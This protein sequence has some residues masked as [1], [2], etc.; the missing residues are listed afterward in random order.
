MIEK[1]CISID[2]ID[3]SEKI[4][5]NLIDNEEKIDVSITDYND[6]EIRN[7]IN[8]ITEE[9]EN[10]VDKE[11]NKGLSTNDYTTAE[12]NKLANLEN[13]DDTEV[14]NLINTK[15][16]KGDYALK[17]EIPTKTS[18]LI[19]DSDFV[20][21]S[22]YVH[23]DNNYTTNEKTKLASLNNY[24]DTEIKEDITDLET[25]KAD[26]TEIPDVSNFITNTVDNLVNYYKKSE[27]YTQAEVNSLISTLSGLKLEVVQ[28]LPTEDISTS[29][30]YL[31]PKTTAETGDVYDEYIYVSNNWEHIGSTTADLTGYVKNT[32]YA[33]AQKGGVVKTGF[34]FNVFNSGV[35]YCSELTYESYNTQGNNT[36]IGKATLENVITGKNLYSKP[37]DGIPKTDL[38]SSVQTSLGKADTA[39]QSSDLADYVTNTDY[40]NSATGGVIKVSSTTGTGMSGAG[41]LYASN[42]SY[43]AYNSASD[44]YFIGKGTLENV[45]EGKGIATKSDIPKYYIGTSATGASTRLK[46]VE[47]EGF[48][49]EEGATISVTFTNAQTYNGAPQLNVNDT[50]AIVVQSRAGVNGVRYMWSAGEIIDFTYD[51]TYWVCHGRGFATTSYY[52]LTKLST[53][54]GSDTQSYAL[55]PRSL[56]Y[57]ANYSIAPYYSSSATYEV[58][59]KVRYTYYLYECN[60]AIETAEAWNAEH[61]TQIATVQE[62]IDKIEEGKKYSTSEKV[63]GTWI[64]N[65][66]LYQKTIVLENTTISSSTKEMT[67]LD[68]TNNDIVLVDNMYINCD[69]SSTAGNR[70]KF[71]GNTV[72]NA[73]HYVNVRGWQNNLL[74]QTDLFYYINKAYITVKYTK[75]TE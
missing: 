12:K 7:Q 22:S 19:N 5:V 27:T 66:P 60:T 4:D 52:G 45:I 49:L 63:V 46:V 69:T 23:T 38:D 67:I 17:S 54:A 42:S 61:W 55:T 28:T 9:L 51:G 3:N 70:H 48:V 68:I 41:V 50:G 1:K 34:S 30:I 56:F 6:T 16:D 71:T 43:N 74:L 29:T 26:K 20:E 18:D 31:V 58:G 11:E 21:D 32:D 24:D 2:L 75:T 37:S 13:Y 25:T 73:G 65:R 57:F 44:Y 59:D 8:D 40:A 39:I 10:K 14:R 47:C 36:F 72:D 53:S 35:P 15:Q 33:T 62:Q 64:D